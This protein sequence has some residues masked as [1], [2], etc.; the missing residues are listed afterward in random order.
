MSSA[1]IDI[2]RL[3]RQHAQTSRLLGVDFVPAYRRGV[4]IDSPERPTASGVHAA[5]APPVAIPPV[6]VPRGAPAHQKGL[7]RP[8]AQRALDA[9]RDRYE[10]DAPHEAFV[11]AHTNIVFGEGDPRARLMFVGEAPGEEEDKTGRPFVGRAG[12]LLNKMIEA[13]GLA[14]EDVYICN[15]LKTR[16][17]NNATPTPTEAALCEPYLLE[18]IGIVAPEVIVTLGLPA[19]RTLL[20]SDE[21]MARLRGRWGS[22]ALP[23]GRAIPVMPT[24]HPAYLLR[25]YTPEARGKV[26]ADLCLAM[27]RLGLQP[28]KGRPAS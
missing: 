22:L 26:W 14:R 6:A 4:E 2:E 15:V 11:T 17:P 7:D 28:P 24:Y 8:A 12:Q 27:E 21:S 25:N 5:S 3:V 18:Q 19:T 20:K 23:D 9:L 16:P 13:I 10:R 1:P